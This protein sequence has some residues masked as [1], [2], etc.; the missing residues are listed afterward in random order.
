MTDVIALARRLLGDRPPI[1]DVGLLASAIGCPMNNRRRPGRLPHHLAR[2]PPRCCGPSSSNHALIDGNKRLGWLATAVF[3]E[4]NESQH[5]GSDGNDNVYDL[6]IAVAASAVD[7]RSDRTEARTAPRAPG[8]T[9]TNAAPPAVGDG[10]PRPTPSAPSR[11]WVHALTSRIAR[12]AIIFTTSGWLGVPAVT[13][14]PCWSHREVGLTCSSRRSAPRRRRAESN[15]RIALCSTAADLM[16]PQLSG[17]FP[18][19]GSGRG[20]AGE[21]SPDGWTEATSRTHTGE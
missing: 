5:G 11:L 6:V 17:T 3:L 9:C 16:K 10:C 12:G 21:R 13:D 8:L 14:R 7:H 19:P 2:K 20:A 15:R 18:A 4:L 1:R